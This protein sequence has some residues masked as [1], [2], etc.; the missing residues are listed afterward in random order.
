[1]TSDSRSDFSRLLIDHF[2]ACGDDDSDMCVSVSRVTVAAEEK[3]Y[4]QNAQ[5]WK[6]Y[7]NSVSYLLQGA[8]WFVDV[9]D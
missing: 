7:L 5:K 8:V 2:A 9:A 6:V 3:R 1:M 4:L